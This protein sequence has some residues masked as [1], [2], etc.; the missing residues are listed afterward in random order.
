MECPPP[1]LKSETKK[2]DN[3]C[4]VLTTEQKNGSSF[5]KKLFYKKRFYLKFWILFQ[6]NKIW[7]IISFL[8]VRKLMK[9]SFIFFELLC[10]DKIGVI[11]VISE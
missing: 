2:G 8:V 1:T 6:R 7:R 3:T 10:L 11:R 4:Y 9:L 5:K